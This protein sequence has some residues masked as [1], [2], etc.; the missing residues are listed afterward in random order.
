MNAIQRSLAVLRSRRLSLFSVIITTV[1]FFPFS[2][3]AAGTLRTV[4]LTG[5]PAPGTTL[6]FL[7]MAVGPVVINDAG[8][9][10]FGAVLSANGGD[11][12]IWSEGSGTLALVARTDMPAPGPPNNLEFF[13]T[14]VPSLNNAGQ[15]AFWS[16]VGFSRES[17][18]LEELGGLEP[19]ALAGTAAPG[20][21]PAVNFRT[22]SPFFSFNDAGQAAFTALLSGTGV[23]A[24]NINSMWSNG[25]GSLAMLARTGSQAPGTPSG[26]N[27]DN[28]GTVQLNSAGQSAFFATLAGAG[29]TDDN[30]RGIWSNR[31]GSIALVVRGGS[32][33]HGLPA[34]VSYTNVFNGGFNS[35]GQ[36][37]LVASL[38]GAGVHSENNHGVWLERSGDF[39]LVA[40]K[41]EQAPGTPS[42]VNYGSFQ[43]TA[44]NDAGRLA[45][46]AG[47]VGDGVDSTNDSGLWVE[48]STG[49]N[50]VARG[51]SQAPGTAS[52]VTF[53]E[54]GNLAFNDAGQVALTVTLAGIG[55]GDSND[56]GIFATDRTGAPHLIARTG[57]LL[58]VAAG[59]SRVVSHLQFAGGSGGGDGRRIGLNR[60]GQV[61]FRA[62][63]ADGSSGAFVS[64]LVAVPEPT[65]LGLAALSS[66]AFLWRR[67]R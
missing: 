52:G 22:V 57:D 35:A 46:A 7:A 44:L 11:R 3:N 21:S 27:F 20:T 24:A 56:Q 53:G 15:T 13:L 39:V 55:V 51:G 23:T 32:Q 25:G 28:F 17:L 9:T 49:L 34:G 5:Q 45:F 36:I 16:L 33:A 58:E 37:A 30:N 4:A 63:F 14:G 47:L 29:V 42:G 59:D 54:F 43:S 66:F 61:A 38:A 40:R 41:G 48:S 10:A 64:N 2:S 6:N 8:Q 67:R 26:V 65:A 62:V 1:G 60:A 12:G 31:T 18:W 19:V 50:L